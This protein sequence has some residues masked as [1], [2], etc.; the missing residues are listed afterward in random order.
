M[1][2][3]VFQLSAGYVDAKGAQG[4]IKSFVSVDTDTH[5]VTLYGA[6]LGFVDAL[7]NAQLFSAP[8]V[9][10]ALTISGDYGTAAEFDSVT[11]KAVMTFIDSAGQIH[12]FQIPAPKAAIFLADKITVNR[13]QTDVAAYVNLIVNGGSNPYFMSTRGGLQFSSFAGGLRIKKPNRKRMTI[14]TKSGN[15]DEPAE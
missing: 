9:G 3:T 1:P 11:D 4:R 15:L 7:T 5:G 12:R 2:N 6:W 10:G 8:G 13:A 14:F